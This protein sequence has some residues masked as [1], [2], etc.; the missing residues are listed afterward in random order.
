MWSA[1]VEANDQN[2]DAFDESQKLLYQLAEA[3]RQLGDSSAETTAAQA[4]G[5]NTSPGEHMEVAADLA[6]R[7]LFQWAEAEYRAVIE[8]TEIVSR[9]HIFARR[10]LAEMLHDQ[11]KD[12][13]AAEALE[14]ISAAME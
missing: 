4:R 14:P 7:G 2:K 8:S 5:F 10:G 6:K 13:A 12:L 1:V 11:E 9:E 3:Q